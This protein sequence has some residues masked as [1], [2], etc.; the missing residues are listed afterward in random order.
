M[1]DM[2][3]ISKAVIAAEKVLIERERRIAELT[4]TVEQMSPKAE[5]FDDLVDRNTL[6]GIRE[7]AK[8]LDVRQNDFVGFLL[9]S[10]YCYRDQ[11]NK[12]QP[13]AEYVGEYFELKETKSDRNG[14]SGTQLM[15]TP[16]GREAFRLLVKVPGIMRAN[17]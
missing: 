7:T 6:T 13:F 3:L 17:A 15:I 5:Y 8:E 9:N 2:E 12:L 11:K 1:T 4:G 16:K 14:W 10:K